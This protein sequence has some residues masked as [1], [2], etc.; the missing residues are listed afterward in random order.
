LTVYRAGKDSYL[1]DLDGLGARIVGGRWNSKGVPMIYTSE[2]IPLCML[3]VLVHV[4]LNLIPDDYKI[5][6][7]QIPDSMDVLELLPTKLPA[8]WNKIPHSA[9]TQK[10]GDEFIL[11]NKYL[12]FKVPSV[13]APGSFN[14]LINPVHPEIKK[15][16]ILHVGEFFLDSRFMK[17]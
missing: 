12:V 15:V 16:K 8:D 3:E 1:K 14:Y 7:I 10:I 9:S 13:V 5:A 2:N 6:Q 4:P 11:A 17:K